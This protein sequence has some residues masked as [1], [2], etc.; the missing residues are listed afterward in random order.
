VPEFIKRKNMNYLEDELTAVTICANE[1]THH[2]GWYSN[3]E[4][5][6]FFGLFST[7]IK[8]YTCSLCGKILQGE[9]LKKFKAG[10]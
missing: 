3:L 7:T 5:S 1:C 9:E 4:V 2:T 6:F 10:K 8:I